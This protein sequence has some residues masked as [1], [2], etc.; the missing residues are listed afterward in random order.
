MGFV[1]FVLIYKWLSEKISTFGMDLMFNLMTWATGIALVLVTL[2]VMIQGY[3]MITGQS[4]ESMMALV[5][6]MTRIVIIVTVAVSMSAFGAN[7]H[8]FLTTDLSTEVNQLFTGDNNTAAQTIDDNLAW[9]QLALAAIDTVKIGPGDTETI[10][11]KNHAMMMAGFGTASPPMAAAAMLLLYQFT[12]AIFIGLGPLFILCLIFDQTKSLF[13]RW[14]LYGIGTIFSMAV[15]AFVSSL[16]LQLTLRVS[17]ALWTADTINAI[18]GQGAEG[19]STQALEQGG[20]GLLM[21]VLIV[22]VP[23]LAA[24]FFQGTVGNFLTY[25]AFGAGPASRLGPQGQPPGSYGAGAGG[26]GRFGTPPQ[27]SPVYDGGGRSMYGSTGA[28]PGARGTI[29]PGPTRGETIPVRTQS[30]ERG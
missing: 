28:H 17:A 11:Q 30:I 10:E 4:R 12:L 18:T 27:S 24:A 22:S 8:Q 15:L 29:V 16:V 7:L 3:R 9:T 2:W 21:T 13:Q 1:Y 20:L 6:N 26:G 25:S 19:F 23:P 14:L 5:M